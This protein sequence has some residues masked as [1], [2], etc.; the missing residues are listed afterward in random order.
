LVTDDTGPVPFTAS[1]PAAV[2]PL[3][4]RG[5]WVT[6]GLVTGSV[7]P[8][9]PSFLPLGLTHDQTH[10]PPALFWPDGVLAVG[11]LLAWWV[12]LRPGLAP[13]WP[14][15]AAR[16][17]PAGWRDPELRSS[18][19]AVVRWVGWLG[20]SELVGLVTHLGWD[21]FT[22]SDGYLARR[23]A[24]LQGDF[25]G[26]LIVN[27]LQALSSVVGLTV[28][29]AYLAVQ[30]QRHPA[31]DVVEHVGSR[32]RLAVVAASLAVALAAA[33]LE[34][35]HV[36]AND[37]TRLALWSDSVKA[38]CGALIVALG[39]WSF[40]WA[41]LRAHRHTTRDPHSQVPSSVP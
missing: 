5:S 38:G 36:S 14:H 35:H 23:W 19:R 10:P 34:Y 18:P 40:G 3:L 15:A 28:V 7:A 17:G 39:L 30:W 2:L 4:R 25:A 11:L 16:G 12:L 20:L 9:L 37:A 1:H 21:A 32:L 33:G 31:P 29:V 8:D 41:G 27:W 6:A 26:H 13:L 22:H 24:P